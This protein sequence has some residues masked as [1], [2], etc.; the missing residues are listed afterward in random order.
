G[1]RPFKG[2]IFALREKHLNESLPALSSVMPEI[3]PYFDQVLLKATAKEPSERFDTVNEFIAALEGACREIDYDRQYQEI[4]TLID[5]QQYPLALNQLERDF[6][7]PGNYEFRDVSRLLWGL[8]HAKRNDG[9]FP[10]DW[11][12]DPALQTKPIPE[13]D[14]TATTDEFDLEKTEAELVQLNRHHET[15][16]YFI[17]LALGL[18]MVI[19]AFIGPKFAAMLQVPVAMQIVVFLLFVGCFGYYSWSYYLT[20]PARDK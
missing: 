8:V 10:P 4:K 17:P 9:A 1:Q 15:N 19:G 6:I 14:A 16:R 7:T 5:H 12:D 20:S 11:L 2:D 18:A 13:F 3:G